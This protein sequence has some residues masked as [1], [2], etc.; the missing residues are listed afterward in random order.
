MIK[1]TMLFLNV[2]PVKVVLVKPEVQY[3]SDSALLR[4]KF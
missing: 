1:T 3:F 4:K 2:K